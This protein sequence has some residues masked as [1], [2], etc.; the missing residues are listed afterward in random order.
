MSRPSYF[1]EL[2]VSGL[3]SHALTN[4]GSRIEVYIISDFR[5]PNCQRVEEML[6][7]IYEKYNKK[8]CI[9]FIFCSDYI[10]EMA[11]ACEA[12]WKQN[13]FSQMRDLIFENKR[14][15]DRDSIG[16]TLARTLGLNMIKFN[17]DI[18]DNQIFKSC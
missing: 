11:M 7:K 8:V 17:Q 13:K 14:Q 12:A 9:K 16:Y 1:K 18:N 6:K 3:F 15:L 2:N 10:D 5:C 4:S